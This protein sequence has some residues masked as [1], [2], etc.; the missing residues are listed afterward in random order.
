MISF[1]KQLAKVLLKRSVIVDIVPPIQFVGWRMATGTC[2]PWNDVGSNSLGM[3]FES[4]DMELANQI[5]SR[6]VILTQFNQSSVSIEVAQLRWRHY[7]VYWSATFASKNASSGTRNFVELGVCDG[8]TAWYASR[9]RQ[10]LGCE[11]EFFLYDAWEEMR[12]DLLTES[13]KKS[14]GSYSYLD[15]ENTRRN[16]A[17]CGDDHFVFVKGY[18]PE[19]FAQS[20]TPEHIAWMHIDLNASMPTLASL[21]F[22]GDRLLPGGVILLDDFAWPG[23]EDTKNEV[24][25]WC[26]SQGLDILQFPTGQALIIKQV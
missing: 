14:A 7:I 9:A 10:R 23:Y 1:I 22:F 13:E 16:L 21:E 6:N 12:S 20:R 18:I 19:S 26:L 11:G 25:E 4:C 5:V 17:F 24:E 8:L 15:I 3:A 2:P